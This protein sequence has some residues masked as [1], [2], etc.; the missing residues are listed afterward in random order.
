MKRAPAHLHARSG[1]SLL[2]TVMALS[3]L[4]IVLSSVVELRSG[5]SGAVETPSSRAL[6]DGQALS[7]AM[8]AANRIGHVS[9][10][11]TA[12]PPGAP[13]FSS[14]FLFRPL[15]DVD[16]NGDA[17]WGDVQRLHAEDDPLDPF[18]GADND[19]DGLT[20]EMRLIY[21]RS[22]GSA[23]EVRVVIARDIARWAE[24]E[25][26]NGED[27]NDND[28]IDEPGFCVWSDGEDLRIQVTI[29]STVAP[30]SMAKV[31]IRTM[32]ELGS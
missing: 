29:D 32:S 6:V 17:V 24:G 4:V 3:I 30:A 25:S 12:M 22:V 7:V 13:F 31:P 1:V 26:R 5:L 28:L 14:D 15:A 11:T 19:G 10:S 18:D 27:D 2:E 21:T 23:S 9:S 20:D 8:N 16:A